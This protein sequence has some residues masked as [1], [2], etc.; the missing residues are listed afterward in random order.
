MITPGQAFYG[1]SRLA[2]PYT[3]A[4]VLAGQVIRISPAL[5]TITDG[6]VDREP[7]AALQREVVAQVQ[8]LLEHGVRSFHVDVNFDDYGGFGSQP[9]DRNAHVFDPAFVRDLNAL[10][11]GQDAFLTLHL[12]TDNPTQHLRTYTGIPLGAICFQLD[13]VPDPAALADLVGQITAMGACASPVI[14]TVGTESLSPAAPDVV[15]Q[16]LAPVRHAVMLTL[17]AA[18]TGTR[19]NQAAG[20]LAEAE[21]AA[22][23]AALRP[24]F[25]GTVQLQGGIKIETVGAAVRLG[26]EFL[27]AGT[28]LFRHPHDL[29]TAHVIDQMLLQAAS[30]LTG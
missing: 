7:A 21:V 6:R 20:A 5:I 24:T 12:L 25:G 17:Q 4:D 15:R 22:H 27:V 28:Q 3:R 23:L 16:Q 10:V 26:A 9:P 29:P 18:G 11:A 1:M 13:A 19:S 8:T 14:E 2:R 30:V